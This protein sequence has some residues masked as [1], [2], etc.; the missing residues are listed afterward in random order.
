MGKTV[1]ILDWRPIATTPADADLELSAFDTSEYAVAFWCFPAD[2]MGWAGA[3][4][5]L[6][7]P[8]RFSRPIGDGGF[9]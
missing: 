7:G 8:C 1:S 6:I 5:A 9:V 3:M 2:V 4:C